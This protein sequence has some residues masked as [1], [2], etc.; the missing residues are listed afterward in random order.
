[1]IDRN[2]Q[3]GWTDAQWN[4]VRQAVT[5]A[6]Q[7]VRVAGSL[8]SNYGP[9]PASTAVVQSEVI[10][11]TGNVDD[12]STARV[13]ELYVNV[14]LSRQQVNEDDLSDAALVFKRAGAALARE[15]DRFVFNGQQPGATYQ[16]AQMQATLAAPN[17]AR[18]PAVQH[19]GGEPNLQAL[20]QPELSQ[21]VTALINT[22]F[23]TVQPIQNYLTNPAA[24]VVSPLVT[25]FNTAPGALGLVFAAATAINVVGLTGAHLVTEVVNAIGRLDDAGYGAPFACFLSRNPYIVART[26][27]AAAL[28]MPSDRIEPLLGQAII[29]APAL[30]E[31]PTPVPLGTYRGRGLVLSLAG[32]ALDLALASAATPTFVNINEQGDYVFR[33]FERFALRV[34]DNNAIVRL[35]FT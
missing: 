28:I 29:R 9:M 1:M 5:A 24:P 23:S 17:V 35:E 11:Q 8:L 20:L 3:L 30:D 26:P 12:A 14:S 27:V 13:L 18:F 25:I 21:H 7:G 33:V 34:K 4:Q 19:E 15:E 32:D 2:G 10:D 22:G 16:G 31:G 6:W